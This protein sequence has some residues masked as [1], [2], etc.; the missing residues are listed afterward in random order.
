MMGIVI[1]VSIVSYSRLLRGILT[2][3]TTLKF[4]LVFYIS[5][6]V[7]KDRTRNDVLFDLSKI[8]KGSQAFLEINLTGLEGIKEDSPTQFLFQNIFLKIKFQR[9]FLYSDEPL[10]KYSTLITS[11]FS[12][13]CFLTMI[14]LRC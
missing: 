10:G 5:G 4:S 11:L 14:E 13:K 12:S 8:P 6:G 1:L 7:G 2:Y 9:E 3:K